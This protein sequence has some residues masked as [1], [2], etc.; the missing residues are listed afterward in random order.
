MAAGHALRIRLQVPVQ[1][2]VDAQAV[3]PDEI[4]VF[5]RVVLLLDLVEHVERKVRC[6]GRHLEAFLRRLARV[7]PERAGQPLGRVGLFLGQQVGL[8]QRVQRPSGR[9]AGRRWRRAAGRSG[10]VTLFD[11]VVQQRRVEV[12]RRRRGLL[13]AQVARLDHRV[14]H[15]A[16]AAVRIRGRLEGVEARVLRD[17]SQHGDLVQRQVAHVLVV[18]D[19]RGGLDAVRR[20]AVE[21][22]VE[23]PLEDLLFA[24][25]AGVLARDLDRQDRFL[26]LAR[27]RL[28]VALLRVDQDVLDQLLRDRARALHLVAAQVGDER[29][30]KAAQVHADVGV[31]VAV[32][33]RN[34]R[35]LD[36]LR[37][38]IRRK[39][40]AIAAE[41]ARVDR[42]VQ[43]VRAGA[44]VDL[45]RLVGFLLRLDR[46]RIGQV[47]RKERVD[48]GG[49]HGRPEDRRESQEE[50]DRQQ[51]ACD[52]EKPFAV[53]RAA[54]GAAVAA[55]GLDLFGA[56]HSRVDNSKAK[57]R[58]CCLHVRSPR[59]PIS[60]ATRLSVRPLYSFLDRG[61]LT[62]PAVSLE[63]V[64]QGGLQSV[65]GV[66]PTTPRSIATSV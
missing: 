39:V 14:E 57:R 20:V 50:E 10:E 59:W 12:T 3:L 56:V 28:L 46:R 45:D 60:K 37:D 9:R 36:Q 15:L 6:V 62:G 66:V 30:R 40:G 44:I 34:R 64:F 24:L 13:G 21:V 23:I 5:R 61:R 51:A 43:Q 33:Q 11:Q 49:R 29:A 22:I 38:L 32:L 53:V 4:R 17:G 48:A 47:L 2:R 35:V 42:L 31:E 52:D 1:R 55:P 58:V 19:L 18:I 27:V 7:L 26:E 8:D 54:V 16:L 25:A 63:G 41:G 65:R